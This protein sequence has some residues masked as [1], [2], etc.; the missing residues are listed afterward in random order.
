LRRLNPLLFLL[1]VIVILISFI[2]LVNQYKQ[3]QNILIKEIQADQKIVNQI[4]TYKKI[5]NNKKL[6][7]KNI[8]LFYNL[9][10]VKHIMYH[11][12]F[13]SDRIGFIFKNID[14]KKAKLVLSYILN[15]PFQIQLLK[16]K[17]LSNAHFELNIEML[18]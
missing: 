9:L 1:F 13:I 3:K 6:N 11:Q 2:V 4:I 7:N 12:Y 5:W 8:K 14:K 15:K 16:I 10:Q 18:R 17:R